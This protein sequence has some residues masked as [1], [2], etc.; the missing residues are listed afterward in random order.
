MRRS[1]GPCLALCRIGRELSVENFFAD[2]ALCSIAQDQSS[3]MRH[4]A[5][6]SMFVENH[7]FENS[8]F[9][10]FDVFCRAGH[11]RY[12]YFA[13]RYLA[14]SEKIRKI[15]DL[16]CSGLAVAYCKVS[17]LLFATFFIKN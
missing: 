15:A 14:N 2:P 4:S 9:V 13:I 6:P 1:A 7:F 12:K 16:K 5:G 3:A 17:L 11:L 8:I 10:I